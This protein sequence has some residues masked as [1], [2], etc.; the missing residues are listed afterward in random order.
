MNIE[1]KMH[2][3]M[4]SIGVGLVISGV[5]LWLSWNYSHDA[6]IGVPV[7]ILSL[8]FLPGSLLYVMISTRRDLSVTWTWLSLMLASG[9]TFYGFVVFIAW[10]AMKAVRRRG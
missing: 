10:S 7:N 2:V 8:P 3:V 1:V 6:A 5:V 9:A 4:A